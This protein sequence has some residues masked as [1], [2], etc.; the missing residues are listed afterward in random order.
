MDDA[1]ENVTP[2]KALG[3]TTLWWDKNNSRE[4]NLA[5]FLRLIDYK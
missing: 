1:L 3:M 2:A 5:Q 4:E